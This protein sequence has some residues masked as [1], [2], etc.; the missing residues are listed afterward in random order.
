MTT[1]TA[2]RKHNPSTSKYDPIDPWADAPIKGVRVMPVQGP[3]IATRHMVLG[4][5]EEGF[6]WRW[7]SGLWDRAAYRLCR[8]LQEAVTSHQEK[9]AQFPDFD[10]MPE[11]VRFYHWSGTKWNPNVALP[12][13]RCWS[14]MAGDL[15]GDKS[16]AEWID[17]HRSHWKVVLVDEDPKPKVES[18]LDIQ[19]KVN[20]ALGE[21]KVVGTHGG[22]PIVV[23]HSH[24]ALDEP[25]SWY[26][27]KPI[28]L[29]SGAILGE[30]ANRF[31]LD[32]WS[33]PKEEPEIQ[34]GDVIRDLDNGTLWYAHSSPSV[35]TK[36]QSYQQIGAK[37]LSVPTVVRAV[38][39]QKPKRY[40]VISKAVVS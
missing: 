38:N 14:R 5:F 30:V 25:I 35:T 2:T 13:G 15:L 27:G 36:V 40:R 9:G 11:G 4:D 23:H 22:T 3:A 31:Y 6:A 10:G 21:P 28:S 8:S 1:A 26:T 18:V 12:D 29:R 39:W 24:P 7:P 20:K 34:P 33:K 19:D 16:A 37:N 17:W 32:S